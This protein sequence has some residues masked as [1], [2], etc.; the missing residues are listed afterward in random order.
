MIYNDRKLTVPEVTLRFATDLI[1][2]QEIKGAEHNPVIVQMFADIGHA[3]VKD[4]ETA[5]CSAVMNWIALKL[6]L[7]RSGALDA[8]SWLEVGQPIKH[9]LPGDVVVFWRGSL[10]TWKGHVGIFVGY[11][12]NGDIFC[13]GGNQGNEYDI[14]VYGSERVLGFRR[15]IRNTKL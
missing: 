1:G 11:N 7:T 15:L 14:S 2:L 12:H 5:W 10:S 4:D 13:L 8:R 3:W 9:P 6:G